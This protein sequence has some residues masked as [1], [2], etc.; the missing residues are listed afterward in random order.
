ML[1]SQVLS[2]SLTVSLYSTGLEMNL[3]LKSHG[4]DISTYIAPLNCFVCTYVDALF[5]ILL[6]FEPLRTCNRCGT[7]ATLSW[8][9]SSPP[10]DGLWCACIMT[11]LY[12]MLSLQRLQRGMCRYRIKCLVFL[13]QPAVSHSNLE[14]LI[15]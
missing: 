1:F 5:M 9:H 8:S 10:F 15:P 3:N 2:V 6:M 13:V 14:N 12:K 4:A 11:K 7:P